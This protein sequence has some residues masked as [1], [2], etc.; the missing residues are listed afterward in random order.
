MKNKNITPRNENNQT[1]GYW[2]IGQLKRK[3]Y[4]I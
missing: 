2:A 3:T 4:H 1:Y